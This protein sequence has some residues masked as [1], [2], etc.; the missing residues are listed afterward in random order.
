MLNWFDQFLNWFHFE[1]AF[2]FCRTQFRNVRFWRWI[3][4]HY[5]DI[6]GTWNILLVLDPVRVF[7][8]NVINYLSTS[9][10]SLIS[11]TKLLIDFGVASKRSNWINWIC[12]HQA[13]DQVTHVVGI[14]TQLSPEIKISVSIAKCQSATGWNCLAFDFYQLSESN[15]RSFEAN[16]SSLKN[17]IDTFVKKSTDILNL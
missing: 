16:P 10:G 4:N 13:W 12:T 2:L 7:N 6:Q 1:R 14:T 17:C 11:N 5:K 8:W 3:M 9:K 15:I